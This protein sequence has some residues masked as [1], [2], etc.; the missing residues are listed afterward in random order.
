MSEGLIESPT[1]LGLEH[2]DDSN[3]VIGLTAEEFAEAKANAVFMTYTG[4]LFNPFDPQPEDINI[5]DIA[6]ALSQTCRYGGM[7]SEYYSVAQHSG[8]VSSQCT[9]KDDWKLWGLLHDAAEAYIGDM[10]KPFKPFMLN[11][12]NLETIILKVIA[13]K[14]DLKWYDN[15]DVQDGVPGHV[16]AVDEQMLYTE[17]RQLLP[18]C[19]WAKED[20]SRPTTAGYKDMIIPS[21]SPEQAKA[22][23]L[24]EFSRQYF[25]R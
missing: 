6:H 25:R 10:P 14:F 8:H 15:N 13:D 5:Q 22:A 21:M 17:A 4:R 19:D 9:D 12:D 1:S 23:F 20:K 24:L 18:G 3:L 7:C 16:S 11:F 2:D